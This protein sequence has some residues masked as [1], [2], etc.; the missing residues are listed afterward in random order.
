MSNATFAPVIVDNI[1]RPS[2]IISFDDLRNS[3]K[4]SQ[5]DAK[6]TKHKNTKS[7][8]VYAFKTKEEIA[9]MISVLDKH[10]NE[11]PN[12][13]NR[14]I[15]MRNKML[16]VIGINIGIRAS[17]LRTL[18][19]KFFIKSID[20]NGKPVFNEAYSLCPVKTRKNKKYV[21]LHFN[22]AVK[23]IITQFIEEYPIQSLNDYLFFSRVG[24]E[25]MVVRSICRVIK[26]TAIEAGIN[27]NIGSHS[28]RKSFGFWVWHEADDKEKALVILSYIWN[29]SSVSTTRKYIGLTSEDAEDVFS[30]LNLGIDMI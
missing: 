28:L 20:E 21:H 6:T 29:H 2:N 23:T 30:N 25:P 26:E 9:A 16:F 12:D 11:A 19:Y 27:Q 10:I 15:A 17:D 1:G 3:K 4:D 24:D 8:E 5:T 7:S 14:R 13:D 22:D 18:Q